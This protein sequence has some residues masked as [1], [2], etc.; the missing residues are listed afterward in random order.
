VTGTRIKLEDFG[1]MIPRRSARLLPPNFSADAR[2]VRLYSG[3]IRGLRNL[4]GLADLSADNAVRAY[5]LPNPDTV[6]GYTWLGLDSMDTS[7]FRGPLLNDAYDRYYMFGA[8][9]PKYNTLERIEDGD[10][11]FRLGI[12]VAGDATSLTPTGGTGDEEERFYIYTFV[13]AYGEE[14]PPCTPISATGPVDASWDLVGTDTTV[15]NPT[16]RNITKKRIYRTVAGYSSAE[17]FFV[18]EITL[19]TANYSD[20]I[21]SDVVSR[22]NIFE[23]SQ[24]FEPP[25]DI[26]GALIMPNGFFLAWTDRDVYFSEAYRPHAWP[27]AYGQSTEFNVLAAGVYGVSAVLATEGNPYT[28]TGVSPESITL[29]KNNTVE[30]CLSKYSLVSF[31]DAVIYASQNGLVSV[32][33]SGV[34]IATQKLLT[35]AVWMKNYNPEG[36]VAAQY[37]NEYLAFYNTNSGFILNPE[38]QNATF[39]ELDQFDNMDSIQTDPFTGDVFCMRDGSAYLWDADG[40]LH[41]QYTWRSKDFVFAKPCNMGAAYISIA[42]DTEEEFETIDAIIAWNTARID[43]PLTTFGSGGAFGEAMFQPL[44][45][46]YDEVAQIKG[47]LAGSPLIVVDNAYFGENIVRFNVYA[48]GVLVYT[49]LV[50]DTKMLQRLPSGFKARR[51]AFEV[52]GKR[53]VYSIKVAETGKG[54][55]DV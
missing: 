1:G 21:D 14:G 30:P 45:S 50:D 11:W 43:Y 37:E 52:V 40:Q 42:P 28:A 4:E 3:E 6:S 54:L 18:A 33:S 15:P 36:I 55:Q 16:E 29:T 10:P 35:K 39:V 22:N 25:Q 53:T 13:S 34:R 31:P 26:Q 23:A 17:F 8:G 19:A 38:E 20:T 2:N 27:P 49:G 48:D 12:P 41:T 46:P 5:R 47:P 32:S 24:W 7:V 9:Y 44:A 51:W